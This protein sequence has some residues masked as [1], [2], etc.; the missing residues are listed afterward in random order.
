MGEQEEIVYA[1]FNGL[2]RVATVYGVP[3]MVILSAFS[4][5]MLLSVVAALVFGLIGFAFAL[6]IV[7]VFFYLRFLCA[8]DDRA[9]TIL[10]IECEWLAQKLFSGSSQY[11]GGSL[12]IFPIKYGRDDAKRYFE[13]TAKR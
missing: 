7:P 1:S 11:F 10:L 13:K 3:Y 2:G 6:V 12:V 9:F 8:T 4:I 5:C